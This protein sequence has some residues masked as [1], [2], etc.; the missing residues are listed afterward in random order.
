MNKL[1]IFS[2]AAVIVVGGIVFF[3][4]QKKEVPPPVSQAFP[5][6][7]PQKANELPFA[8]A[9][10]AAHYENNTPEHGT[11]LAG[12]PVNVLINFSFDLAKGS[13]IKV[14]MGGKDY[15]VGETSIDEGKLAMRRKIDTSAPDGV[16]TVNY[17]ACWADGSCHDG[18]FQFKI[19]HSQAESFIDMRSKSEVA[20]NLKDISFSPKNVRV[21]KN[22]KITWVNKDNI[23][24]TVNTDSHPGHNFYPAQNSRALK[25]GDT[26]A[27]TFIDAGIYP[28]HCTPHAGSMKGTILVE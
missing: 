18:I 3:A 26:Y 28:Y 19:D 9:K 16:Y 13:E 10:K 8:V 15:A 25:K 27:V 17:K 5:T 2:I 14:E 21:S 6:N 22:T 11:T 7:E 1:V 23:V 12:V 24:H 4:S 20:I